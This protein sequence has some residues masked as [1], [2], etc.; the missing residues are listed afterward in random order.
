MSRATTPLRYEEDDG[1][2]SIRVTPRQSHRSE[3]RRRSP[4]YTSRRKEVTPRT[5]YKS[6]RRRR[7]KSKSKSSFGWDDSTSRDE[8]PPR[9]K[10]RQRRSPGY[11]RRVDLE[12]EEEVYQRDSRKRK[13]RAITYPLRDDEKRGKSPCDV[14]RGRC[15]SEPVGWS[16]ECKLSEKIPDC[17][18][19]DIEAR[20]GTR[21]FRKWFE[22]L[23]PN[24]TVDKD[25][26]TDRGVF[27][28]DNFQS[29]S[30]LDKYLGIRNSRSPTDRQR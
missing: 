19:Y 27:K 3:R 17:R 16:K 24:W 11:R 8:R 9:R 5:K 23:P 6:P 25:V 15:H 13:E 29:S 10:S 7:S 12:E 20:G 22:K 1:W 18:L 26:R 28:K 4:Q 21:D 30:D 2:S 14:P